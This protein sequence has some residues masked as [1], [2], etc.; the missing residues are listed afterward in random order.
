MGNNY[1]DQ[2][3]EFGVDTD[4]QQNESF[5]GFSYNSLSGLG[6]SD[7]ENEDLFNIEA[8]PETVIEQPSYEAPISINDEFKLENEDIFLP[9]EQDPILIEEIPDEDIQELNLTE[10]ETEANLEGFNSEGTEE[11]IKVE[12]FNPEEIQEETNVDE[13]NPEET[14]EET[15]VAESMVPEEIVEQINENENIVMSETPIE[16]LNK[17]TEYDEEIVE[18]TS[19]NDL[20]DKVNV[21]V[22]EASDIFRKNTEMKAKIDSRFNEL[23]DLQSQIEKN[24]KNQM[25]EIDTYKEEVLTKLNEKKDE[26]EKR[27]NTLK[28][29][30]SKLEK[31]KKEFDE[32]KENEQEKIE[33]IKKDVQEAYDERRE[34]LN[35]IEDK[36]RK[37]KDDLDEQRNQLTLDK[38][39]YES[40]K[41]DL[42]NN[43][44]K[45][46]ELVNSFTNGMDGVKEEQ[47]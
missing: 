5:N 39:Q 35:H 8:K 9:M 33:Q 36:L 3:F 1:D 12:E 27:L 30:Q 7:Y 28:E 16:E 26:I 37:Q 21:N 42:A 14:Q 22:K 23:K 29:F 45:F 34:E 31:E 44:L 11:E 15:N 47:E 32:Y 25:T 46:N 40:D 20:F 43:L 17:L 2:M 41:N 6:E 38:I 4:E 24:K 10:Y 19:I 18:S 13:F